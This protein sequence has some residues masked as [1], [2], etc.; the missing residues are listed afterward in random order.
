MLISNVLYAIYEKIK[1]HYTNILDQI[2]ARYNNTDHK[3]I[4]Y[5][6]SY[7]IY[8]NISKISRVYKYKRYFEFYPFYKKGQILKE[9]SQVRVAKLKSVF[10]KESK[11]NWSKEIFI[12]ERVKLTDPVT[13]VLKDRN[14]EISFWC[15]L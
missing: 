6:K 4:D 8:N 3:G 10:D 15:V 5:N 11:F 9:G 7:E 14:G 13:Y 1:G 12:V 2:I